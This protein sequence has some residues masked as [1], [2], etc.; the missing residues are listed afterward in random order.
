MACHHF[1]PLTHERDKNSPTVLKP[2][3]YFVVLFHGIYIAPA[4]LLRSNQAEKIM[5]DFKLDEDTLVES[6]LPAWEMLRFA[7]SIKAHKA[8][9][10]WILLQ[11]IHA[12]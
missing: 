8:L 1:I 5:Q 4:L 7:Q 12:M 2:Y 11:I 9:S 6:F 10:C 3:M